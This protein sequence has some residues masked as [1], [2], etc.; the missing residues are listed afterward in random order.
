MDSYGCDSRQRPSITLDA[1]YVSIS[2]LSIYQSSKTLG[3]HG[4]KLIC[5]IFT[6]ICLF[7]ISFINLIC[8][9]LDIQCLV[10]LMYKLD[11][12]LFDGGGSKLFRFDK[13]NK[14]VEFY[15]HVSLKESIYTT[16]ITNI[17]QINLSPGK[18][19]DIYGD[20]NSILFDDDQILLNTDKFYL[21]NYSL[22]DFTNLQSFKF[23]N[24]MKTRV[25]LNRLN[26][27]HIH[28]KHLS[29]TATNQLAILNITHAFFYSQNLVLEAN[30]HNRRSILRFSNYPI[31][32][33]FFHSYQK[34]SHENL[35]FKSDS[36]FLDLP[37]LPLLGNTHRSESGIY[38]ICICNTTFLFLRSFAHQPCPLC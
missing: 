12:S 24:E 33:R 16:N 38:R 3:L 17:T 31:R 14:E 2:S 21:K 10:W 36:V 35:H 20:Q 32:N 15:K 37:R 9:E 30:R 5:V 26:S 25:H 8:T 28:N 4:K 19:I 6:I 34:T 22:V 7:L 18:Q 23:D 11:W 29:L 1:G 13:Y 27:Q